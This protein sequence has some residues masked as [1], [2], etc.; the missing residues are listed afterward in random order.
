MK[1][2]ARYAVPVMVLVDED[3]DHIER[4]VMVAGERYIDRETM[5]DMLFYT[6]ELER[7]SSSRQEAAHA[8]YVGDYDR[9]PEISEWEIADNWDMLDFLVEE[10]RNPSCPDCDRDGE[11]YTWPED[12]GPDDGGVPCPRCAASGFIN[13]DLGRH[14]DARSDLAA[15]ER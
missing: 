15:D 4:V 8:L 12:A 9:W 2:W 3:E 7:I 5:G 11:G 6:E 14:P 10:Q 13:R 1:V